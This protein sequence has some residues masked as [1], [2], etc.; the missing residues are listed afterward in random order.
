MDRELFVFVCVD[1][2]KV[3]GYVGAGTV[4]FNKTIPRP[5]ALLERC[6]QIPYKGKLLSSYSFFILGPVCI[7]KAYRGRGV[8][9]GM[10][11]KFAEMEH[12][13]DLA[14]GFT[15]VGNDRL[16]TASKKVR[17]EVVGQFEA[18]GQTFWILVIPIQKRK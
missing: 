16:L 9:S 18:E 3:V 12:T 10:A 11:E 6:S 14:I 7:D 2:G 4:E 13:Q 15:P 5:R 8:F 17:S 1:S